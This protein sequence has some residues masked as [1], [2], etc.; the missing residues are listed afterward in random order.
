MTDAWGVVGG[1]G[2]VRVNA[3]EGFASSRP[4]GA[5]QPGTITVEDAVRADGKLPEEAL[6]TT[7]VLD[8]EWVASLLGPECRTTIVV[9]YNPT[10]EA[11]GVVKLWPGSKLVRPR[12]LERAVGSMRY[13]RPLQHAKLMILRF[14]DRV[15]VIISSANLVHEDWTIIGQCVWAA[16]FPI[17]DS[18]VDRGEFADDLFAFL[19]VFLSSE[20]DAYYWTSGYNTSSARA[21]IVASLPG[22]HTNAERAPFALGIARLKQLFSE[23]GMLVS[24]KTSC[25]VKGCT[26]V[27]DTTSSMGVAND[28]WLRSWP[29]GTPRSALSI[30]YP[31]AS[32]MDERSSGVFFCSERAKSAAEPYFARMKW[33]DPR[34]YGVMSHAKMVFW[35]DKTHDVL[36]AYYGSANFSAV[37]WG[38][39]QKTGAIYIS[40]VELGVLLLPDDEG[41]KPSMPSPFVLPPLKYSAT[42]VPFQQEHQIG[43]YT[44]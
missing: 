9:D 8:A 14:D 6:L 4:A 19:R 29:L 42:D 25:S 15:R 40:N 24:T 20:K 43:S 1:G 44:T 23:A 36:A 5:G 17:T 34:R 11:S 16:D 32:E 30:I 37:A 27:V 33:K 18:L 13:G 38:T 41:N 7:Y 28:G 3:I 26:S 21:R 31:T 12:C 39:M 2:C 35:L 22:T 10:R